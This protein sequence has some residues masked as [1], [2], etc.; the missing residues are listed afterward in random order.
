[1]RCSVKHPVSLIACYRLFRN[2]VL[3][4]RGIATEKVLKL[5]FENVFFGRLHDAIRYSRRLAG[6]YDSRKEIVEP[7]LLI[8]G[9]KTRAGK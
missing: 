4:T 8:A 5:K 3:V 7:E 2:R 6:K 1:M 9:R